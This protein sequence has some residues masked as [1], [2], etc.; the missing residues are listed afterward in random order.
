MRCV[1]MSPSEYVERIYDDYLFIALRRVLERHRMVV[2]SPERLRGTAD[3]L[4][5]NIADDL[6][7]VCSFGSRQRGFIALCIRRVLNG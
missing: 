6:D 5:E 4:W 2:M 3:G 7:G 1:T